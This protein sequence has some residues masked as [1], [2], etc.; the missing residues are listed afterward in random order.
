MDPQVRD[1]VRFLEGLEEGNMGTGDLYILS[2]KLDPVM[3]TIV[4]KYLRKKYPATKPEGAGV[5]TRLVELT[6][7]YPDLVKTMKTG[8]SDPIVEWFTETYNFGEF[9]A[10]PEE[11][12]ELVVEKLEG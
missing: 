11:M 5:T 2:Q 12:V 3:I 6:T 1:G 10:K 4:V 9:Y 7:T 8:E